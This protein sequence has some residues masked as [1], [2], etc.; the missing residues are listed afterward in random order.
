MFSRRHPFLFFMLVMAA[1]VFGSATV[2][3][4]VTGVYY[5]GSSVTF[6]MGE[7]VGIVEVDGV[8]LSAWQVVEDLKGFRDDDA[9]KAIVVR[10]DSPG[11]AVGPAQEIFR[12]IRKTAETKKVVASMGSVAASGGY[13]VAASAEKIFANP[14][15]LTGSIG[16]IMSYTNFQDLLGKIGLSPVVIK[17]GEFKDI[18]SPVRPMEEAEKQI[19]QDFADDIHRQFID[20]VAAGRKM[21]PEDVAALADGRIYTGKKALELGL[22]DTLGGLEEAVE[23]AGRMA[24]IEGDIVQ[25]YP[26]RKERFSLMELLT[27]SSAEEMANTLMHRQAVSGGYLYRPGL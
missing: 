16:V 3:S 25:V 7:K 13:Y 26:S 8:I 21:K 12:E 6:E 4:V 20:D 15:T 10:V 5:S 9:I 19:L 18:A 17:S 22:V 1:I 11:G 27:G 14:G 23:A 24:G 2:I